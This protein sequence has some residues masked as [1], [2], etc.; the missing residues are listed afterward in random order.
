MKNQFKN[1]TKMRK[2][3]RNVVNVTK[4]SI[5]KVDL[6]RFFKSDIPKRSKM[7]ANVKKEIL[8]AFEVRD[9]FRDMSISSILDEK[10]E[11]SVLKYE[12]SYFNK[13]NLVDTVSKVEKTVVVP[14]A[15]DV[16]HDTILGT[17]R[18][19]K[20]FVKHTVQTVD[21]IPTIDWNSFSYPQINNVE[22]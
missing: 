11:A 16:V 14:T 17:F 18:K 21:I 12:T 4:E 5:E 9:M 1:Q 8:I 19:G 2:R 10:R 15:Y 20:N 3:I 22:S 13:V 7:A 6:S